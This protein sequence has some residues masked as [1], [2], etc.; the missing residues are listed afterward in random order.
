MPFTD[1]YAYNFQEFLH[2]GTVR[3]EMVLLPQQPGPTNYIM[4]KPSAAVSYKKH[5]VRSSPRRT[6]F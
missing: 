3:H 1:L 6:L 4:N 5:E 2:I